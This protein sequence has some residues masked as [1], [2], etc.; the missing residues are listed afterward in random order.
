MSAADKPD[1]EPD[2]TGSLLDD[3]S[4][5]RRSRPGRLLG[6]V[7]DEGPALQRGGVEGLS[8]RRPRSRGR[9]EPLE[10]YAGN[11]DGRREG[12][13]IDERRAF[14]CTEDERRHPL[15]ERD[16]DEDRLLHGALGEERAPYFFPSQKVRVAAIA[17]SRPSA[18][19]TASRTGVSSMRTANGEPHDGQSRSAEEATPGSRPPHRGQERTVGRASVT[20]TPQRGSRRAPRP[21]RRRPPRRGR[22]RRPTTG[23]PIRR[24]GNARRRRR[25][26]TGRGGGGRR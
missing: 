10:R 14:R 20:A 2:E 8:R 13:A 23:R 9:V 12:G 19:R 24:T 1:R 21:R 22:Q 26:Q 6:R 7:E 4:F 5:L 18:G 25:R 3:G 15:V 17:S 11:P 16:E